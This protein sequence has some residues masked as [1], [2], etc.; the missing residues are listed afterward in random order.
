MGTRHREKFTTKRVRFITTTCK[1]WLDIFTHES[2]FVILR[3]SLLFINA[4]YHVDTLAYVLMP[5]HIHL[6]NLFE[7]GQD[8]SDYMRDF[9]KFT[10]GEIRRKIE[11]DQRLELFSKLCHVEREQKF[12]IWKDRFD[13]LYLDGINNIQTKINYI[14]LNPVR[15]GLVMRAED[16]L[17]SSASFYAT[18]E[19]LFL[20]V[21]D[22]LDALGWRNH[23]SYGQVR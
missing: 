1:D 5:N 6:L 9:K 8:V 17:Y 15:K 7:D 4:K 22:Y 20:K 12:K 10:S 18:G 11:Q 3:N 14:H 23:Y 2:Y 13:D 21:T 19:I 16:Y